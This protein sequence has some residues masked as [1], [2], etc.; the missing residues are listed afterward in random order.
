MSSRRPVAAM[1]FLGLFGAAALFAQSRPLNPTVKVLPRATSNVPAECDEGASP[2]PV[3]PR[4]QIEEIPRQPDVRTDMQVPPSTDLRETLRASQAAAESNDRERFRTALTAARGVVAMYPPG[5]EKTIASD[6]VSVL[7]DVDRLWE[8]QFSSPTGA[9]FDAGA[10]NGALIT[11]LRRYPGYDD[12]VRRQMIVDSNG[13]RFYPTRESRDFLL[14]ES[15]QRLSRLGVRTGTTP[16]AR[17]TTPAA[18]AQPVTPSKPPATSKPS[19][20]KPSATTS[21]GALKAPPTSATPSGVTDRPRTTTSTAKKTSGSPK[22]QTATKRT[23]ASAKKKPGTA[24]AA[25]PAVTPDEDL[26]VPPP[27]VS[28]SSTVA[29]ETIAPLTETVPSDATTTTTMR[30]ETDAAPT[31]TAGK[32][33]TSRSRNIVMP[34]VLILIGIGVLVVLFRASS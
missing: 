25:A 16:V 32:P 21:A 18:L 13:N 14:R 31:T 7:S 8:Y 11:M 20:T 4:V 33:A 24:K 15:A 23:T 12:F 29:T 28:S 17:A 2:V 19:T 1:V 30:A 10:E 9:F 5:G 34:L 22:K 6:V 27:V 26:P 3:P